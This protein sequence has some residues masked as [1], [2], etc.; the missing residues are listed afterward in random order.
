MTAPQVHVPVAGASVPKMFPGET[1]VCLGSGP[2]L[3]DEDVAYC[4]GRARVI[5]VKDAVRL[6]P[7]AD[8]LYGAGLD[9]GRWW[10]RHGEALAPFAGLRY[11][12]D[13]LAARWATVL[14][15]T[16]LSG[17]EM[18]PTGVRIG[19]NSGYQAINLAVHLGAA[20]I[21]LL[22]YDMQTGPGNNDHFFGNHPHGGRVPLQTF[23]PFFDSLVEPL[24]ALNIA[25]VNASRKTALTCFQR[26]IIQ[27]AL[28]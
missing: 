5:A 6:A 11:T 1:L 23:R 18:A 21:V 9:S 24:K 10:A 28:A 12:L 3:C 20:K 2:S 26:A 25:I 16:G 14:K 22:G 15:F 8:V 17:L 13:P 4:R 27:E 19:R 7:W